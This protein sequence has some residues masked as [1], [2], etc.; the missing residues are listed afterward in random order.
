VDRSRAVV[1]KRGFAFTFNPQQREL[2][3][4]YGFHLTNIPNGSFENGSAGW[5][6]AGDAKALPLEAD[7]PWRGN[8][9]LRLSG[10]ATSPR[11]RVSPATRYTTTAHLRFTAPP[12]VT[13]RYFTCKNKPSAKRRVD[14]FHPPSPQP[15]FQTF[16]FVYTTPRDACWVQI[17]LSDSSTIDIDALR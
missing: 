12:S 16:P 5:K 3:D 8:S 17:R 6:I 1:K 15:S 11:I 7:A 13:F 9:F 10:T 2:A 4:L 14:T